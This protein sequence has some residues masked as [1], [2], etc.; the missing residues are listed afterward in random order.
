MT[1]LAVANFL[2]A[3][4]RAALGDQTALAVQLRR[5]ARALIHL[6]AESGLVIVEVIAC[7]RL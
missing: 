3:A 1:L 7:A 5:A 2:V 6:L 4:A